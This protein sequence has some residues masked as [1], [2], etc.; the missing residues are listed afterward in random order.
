MLMMQNKDTSLI[1]CFVGGTLFGVV[2]TVLIAVLSQL[3]IASL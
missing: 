3:L 1:S 2:V